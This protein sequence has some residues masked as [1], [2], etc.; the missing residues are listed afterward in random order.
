MSSY[1][2][3]SLVVTII[4]G[5]KLAAKDANGKSDPYCYIWTG[6]KPSQPLVTSTQKATLNPEWN[7]TF[8]IDKIEGTILKIRMWDYDSIGAHDFMGKL[9]IDLQHHFEN[10]FVAEE[11][12]LPLL[13]S[14][15]RKS[16]VK[17]SLVV[18]IEYRANPYQLSNSMC[19]ARK[20][21][22]YET[23]HGIHLIIGGENTDPLND[24][25][26]LDID[27]LTFT[28]SFNMTKPRA[29]HASCVCPDGSIV[30]SGGNTANSRAPA[31]TTHCEY[32]NPQEFGWHEMSPM[33]EARYRHTINNLPNGGL[34]VM[35]GFN[36]SRASDTAEIYDPVE[37]DWNTRI[38]LPHGPLM[39]H[40]TAVLPNGDIL[41][42][43]GA[44]SHLP[45]NASE[46]VFVYSPA[47]NEFYDLEATSPFC[48][49]FLLTLNS[50]DVVLFPGSDWFDEGIPSQNQKT[51]N[52]ILRVNSGEEA[53]QKMGRATS[54]ST[55]CVYDNYIIA[56]GGRTKGQIIA[57]ANF[58]QLQNT[59]TETLANWKTFPEPL[60]PRVC[61]TAIALPHK[62]GILIF[63]GIGEENRPTKQVEFVDMNLCQGALRS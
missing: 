14:K 16:K 7:E 24:C 29:Y 12:E 44:T 37:E 23:S 31:P 1:L 34:I 38:L 43:G 54:C 63:G 52:N 59:L 22:T 41:V 53:Y 10:P 55:A 25:E 8:P 33:Q 46:A 13:K 42:V 26:A 32:F 18:R 3:G 11:I 58:Y 48:Q 27:D 30:V 45:G 39:G 62:Q 20:G 21:Y 40:K 28:R 17:G 57:K 19:E 9:N 5:N 50:G 2:N 47:T 51:F 60:V 6:K 4:R 56:F 49:H 61:H 35:G 36:G 15:Q